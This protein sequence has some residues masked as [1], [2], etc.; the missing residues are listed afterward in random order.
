MNRKALLPIAISLGVFTV[1]FAVVALFL[2]NASQNTVSNAPSSQTSV[3][4][5]AELP[6]LE[7][8]DTPLAT[9]RQVIGGDLRVSGN[10]SIIDGLTSSSLQLTPL[11]SQTTLQAGQLYTSNDNNL[12]YYNGQTSAN[13][14]G[15]LSAAQVDIAQLQADTAQL[16]TQP[17][18]V[19][20]LQG[21]SGNVVL[22]G[23]SGITISGT[24][25]SNSGVLTVQGRA[26]NV[27]FVGANGISV[28]GTTITNTGVTSL[29]GES[30]ALAVGNGLSVSGG[31]LVNT[32]ITQ[33][34]SNSADLIVSNTGGG[35]YTISYAGSG[36]G[37]TV[38]LAPLVAQED[39]SD[40]ASI[41]FNKTGAGNLIQL[42]TGT[43]ASNKFVVDQT[44]TI[45]NGSINFSQVTGVPSLVN[46]IAGLTGTI[47]LGA[48]LSVSAG[49]L[50]A[51]TS[52]NNLVGTA[53]QINV[54]GSG[55]L[56]LS[57]PQNIA[58][59]SS[60]TFAGLTLTNALSIANGGTGAVTP[61]GA[62]TN[63]GAAA[64]GANSDITSLSGLTTALSVAQ[65]GTGTT[66]LTQNGVL[67]GN[68]TSAVTALTSSAPNQCLVSS[69]LGELSFS[70]C[71][72]AGGVTSLNSKTGAVTIAGLDPTSIDS[73]GASIII[74]DA[75]ASVK[76]LASFN[77]TNFAVLNG[78]VNTVQDI[79]IGAA[80][81]FAGLTLTSA[82]SVANGGTGR[83]SFATNGV[84]LGQGTG[85]LT[86][87]STTTAGLCLVSGTGG[88]LSFS[89]C[90]GATGV[91]SLNGLTGGLTLGV[92]TASSLSQVGSTITI[93][94]AS[95]VIKGLAAFNE[96]NLT[97]TNGVVNT[98]QDINTGATPTFA[99]LTLTSAL[100]VASGGT[101][102][103]T[104]SANSLLIGNG[105]NALSTLSTTVAGQCLA[106]GVGGVL[107][108][109]TCPGAEVVNTLNG[110]SGAVSVTAV[111]P[112]S[113]DTASGV[114]TI[115]DASYTTK[116]LASFN[117]SNFS[118]LDGAVN[119]VQ[120]IGTTASPTF[121]GLSLTTALGVANGGTGA[122]NFAANGVLVGQGASAVTTVG[123]SA[124]GQ[125]LIS[126][127]GGYLSFAT[128]P[129]STGVVSV[130][131][132]VGALTVR[133]VSA[134]SVLSSGTTVTIQDASDTVKG[135]ASF[136]TTNFTV[137]NGAVNTVQDI[138]IDA[139]PTFAGLSLSSPLAVSSGGTGR[140]S[141]TLNGVV[142]GNGASGLLT[143]AATDANQC[144]VSAGDGSLSFVTC[145]G[146][147]G[148]NSLNSLTGAITLNAADPNS[149]SSSGTTITLRDATNVRKG[150]AS[151]DAANFTVASGAVNTVQ[152]IG[153]GATPTFASINLTAPL[154]V[155]NGG[156]GATTAVG[157]R[158]NLGAA[159]S[160]VNTDITSLGSVTD[161]ASSAD[162]TISAT[163]GTVSLQGAAMVLAR[164]NGVNSTQLVFADPSAD[165]IYTLQTAAAGTYDVC[166]TAGNCVGVGGGVTTEGGTVGRLSR[167]V[168]GSA[169]GDSI[170][171]DNGSTVSIAGALSVNTITPT[172]AAV[173]GAVTQSLTLQGS[174]TAI[175]ATDDATTNTLTFATPSGANK[176]ITIPNAS[177]TIAIS[178]TG[179]LVLDS[180]GNLTCPTCLTSGGGGGGATG[181]STVNGITGDITIT[182]SD[183]N[184][185]TTAGT[186]ITI[187][188]ATATRKGIASFNNANLVVTNGNVNTIQD[189][190]TTA[191]P[192]FAGL[193]LTSPLAV[194][195]GGTGRANLPQGLLLGNGTD[196]VEI[197]APTGAS[198]CLASNEEGDLVFVTCPGT[199]VVNFLN[200][201]NG[202]ITIDTVSASS[203]SVGSNSILIQDATAAI[204]GLASFESDNL[205]VTNG[206]VNTIQDISTAAAP[207][208]NGLTLSTALGVAS[209]GTGAST[210]GAARVNLGAAARGANSDITSLSGLTTA[211]SVSQGGTGQTSLAANRVL[212]GNGTS[213]V[214][215]TNAAGNGLCLVGNS[216]G[217]PSFQMCPG[218]DGVSSLN[219]LQGEVTIDT[220]GATS[221]LVSGNNIRIQDATSS[222]KGLAS[223]DGSNLVVT[224]GA[225]TTAQN[226]TASATPTFAGLNLTAAL[227]VASGGTG[228]TSFTT[229]GILVGQGAGA[230]TTVATTTAG[231]CLVSGTGGSLSFATCPGS[232][233]VSSVNSLTGDVTID[234]VTASSLQVTGNTIRIQD[235][236]S[237]TKGLA[238]FNTDS[239][240]VTNGAV[241]TVQS[242]NTSATPT[243]A[244]LTLTTPLGVAS[245]G[246]GR[247][248]LPANALVIGNGTGAVTSLGTS[249]SGKC[250]VSGVGGVLSFVDCPG[251]D[252][253]NSI[254]GVTGAVSL[255]AVDPAS[256]DTTGSTITIRDA[257]Y[258]TKGLA[259]FNGGNFIVTNG[260]VN[261]IQNISLTATPTFAGLNL[262]TALGVGS[263]GTGSTNFA[264]NSLLVGQGASAVTTV[265]TSTAGQCLVSGT[266]G[267]LSFAACP[268]ANGV[269]SFNSLAGAITL[270]TV[271]A[272]SLLTSGNTITIADASDTIKGLAAFNEDNLTVT[273]GLVNTIQDISTASAPTFAG[274]TLTNALS[275]ANGGTGQ[276][277][278][279]ANRVL[280]GNGS[281][282][283][284]VTNAAAAGQ[285][286]IGNGVGAPSFQACPVGG[287]ISSGTSQTAG[288]VAMF[289]TTTNQ[290]TDSLLSQAGGVVTVDGQL[291]ATSLAGNGSA[292]TGL[293]A[294]N[295]SS[296]TLANARLSSSVTLQG[297]TFNGDSQLVK[298]D[299][300]GAALADGLCLMSTA[301]GT[302]TAFQACPG[303]GG[304]EGAS[305]SLSNLSNVA[306][307]DVLL[308]GAS[309]TID[310]GSSSLLFHDLYLGGDISAAGAINGLSLTSTSLQSAGALTISSGGTNQTLTLAGS[311]T[312]G[313]TINGGTGA[314]TL[315]G[316]SCSAAAN[317]GKL[318]TNGAGAITCADDIGGVTVVGTINAQTASANGASISGNTIYLQTA[319]AS[320]PGLVSTGTQ[321]FG[322]NK[323]FNGQVT[324][325]SGTTLQ[326]TLDVSGQS[327]FTG[328]VRIGTSG[329]GVLYTDG[330]GA[331]QK[332]STSGV[333]VG[334]CLGYTGTNTLGF[335]SCGGSG[336]TPFVQGGNAFNATA[337]LGTTDN[338]GVNIVQNGANRIS[339]PNDG[340]I[341]LTPYTNKFVFINT[342]ASDSEADLIV[343]GRIKS[344]TGFRSGNAN[345]V[346]ISQCGGYI[347]NAVVSGGIITNGNCST[348]GSAG[349]AIVQ[350]GNAFNQ[351]LTMGTT[352]N[353]GINLVKQG[354]VMMAI[355][356]D[357]NIDFNPSA[358]KWVR[359]GTSNTD[360]EAQ[361]IV[362]G[363]VKSLT[364]FRVGNSNGITLTCSNGNQTLG[365]PR[366]EGGIITQASC[367]TN[368]SDLAENYAST[369]NLA[370]AEIVMAAGTAPTAVT[371]ATAA[372]REK[373]MGVVSTE[374]AQTLGTEQVPEG[375]PI[376]LTGRVPVKVNGEGGAIAI[377]DKITISSVAGVGKKATNAGMIV[378]TAVETF[379]GVGQGS[380]EVFVNLMYW[381]P[382]TSNFLQAQSAEFATV[383]VTSGLTVTGA[384]TFNSAIV[385]NGHIVTGGGA[386]NYTVG[387]AAG[388]GATIAVEG[389]D[390]AGTIT[391]TTGSGVTAGSLADLV[392]S[393]QYGKSPR[394]IIS[395]Q[396]DASVSARVYPGAKSLSGFSLS[397][398][399]T[400]APNTTYTFDYFIVE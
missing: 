294:T 48:G 396:D 222:I 276:T 78:S 41:A 332:V 242:I 150:L 178:A 132:L 239:L 119:T 319:S 352:D 315:A 111:D 152:D 211:L 131:G 156:T 369:D 284:A 166:T 164:D 268:G 72:G 286:L 325:A 330:G 306:I 162:L 301:S 113:I 379:N 333:T 213:G 225:V 122:T 345:G 199:S 341:I 96:E 289:D 390:T 75:S 108:F 191:T 377:G 251:T 196:P 346:N 57:L 129:G 149:I 250:L 258:T 98:I 24:T 117:G 373:L 170:I 193:T 263:G 287:N 61:G 20:T 123:A 212:L 25:I 259:S 172:A 179:P 42:S 33:I 155:N 273:N 180:N 302:G 252:V 104:I 187:N 357:G 337:V 30:G 246:T 298:L 327:T 181:V 209:G 364:G 167:F 80:P 359:I 39:S 86:S 358:N 262:S 297:N 35:V 114:I 189:I 171:T 85:A 67:I 83:T 304:S 163:S 238:S 204:K 336:G 102:L 267:V 3:S 365:A 399:Q 305:T 397:T 50:V 37:G 372:G 46:S 148:V 160:G 47:G 154:N 6:E 107:S 317:G 323:T 126:G 136:N 64:S 49:Q 363:R 234:T 299:S 8:D 103:S 244:G 334:Y 232:G 188:D 62:R 261:T 320:A 165:V 253:V 210:A 274:L 87:V 353:F 392:F 197:L 112:T 348:G 311:G 285:C 321:S 91:T 120:N 360:G 18:A 208:F 4:T 10:V 7:V 74:R 279:A 374:P 380:I 316:F 371:R 295:I 9:G 256:I 174:T 282:G 52:V 335:Q 100:D 23:T 200:G 291:T 11:S 66:S 12:Y 240:T 230:L 264:A 26:G 351:T 110:Q 266:G 60:P 368:N 217:A 271:T 281:S 366:I 236:T 14:S 312:G 378:G 58:T 28:S 223:F 142:V 347:Q 1:I 139:T 138:T 370:P 69:A 349:Q 367:S 310:I 293:N 387:A 106:S 393:H 328:T 82:L 224:N 329:M 31:T 145:P 216:S 159:A 116:G 13:I 140:S 93:N 2:W 241:S 63:L 248:S 384:A 76:G 283:I 324:V 219:S 194:S 186:T 84:L 388:A 22:T 255:T 201:I 231:Q 168:S 158:A 182:A 32:G 192:T 205:T 326:S 249:L 40:N 190:S 376:A 143:V 55:T 228:R 125:C 27:Q 229:N 34:I 115:K 88:S 394:V 322:G 398:A 290:I 314:I 45:I 19:V 206:H 356:Q 44:G 101:G 278:L 247:S 38:A 391:V 68:G 227:G 153:T 237:S 15:G 235:A 300:G 134:A 303:S 243:F 395:G 269:T 340:N 135:L 71:P 105:T 169:I 207:T 318:T 130:N 215:V 381:S 157:A 385:V 175:T 362:N 288:V 185:I 151:F 195:S 343:N 220:V 309:N 51:T 313:V 280:L 245:G 21:Q 184:T 296:G 36:A 97:V 29:G 202:T 265:G 17:E 308:P 59:T 144:L 275:V 383:N 128:C 375:Y 354:S 161:L 270:T 99:G 307:N 400:L 70:S 386:P 73:T 339:M 260:D 218:S 233:G 350:G 118:V 109:V 92:V 65:G 331:V 137:T 176:T 198:E 133:G 89:T 382:V 43:S 56:T 214:A 90:P 257:S 361:L 53:N 147:T 226:I 344:L 95:E 389:N 254:N 124:E 221:L 121:E 94:D 292:I 77:G 127:S 203:L 146:A 355:S 277:S 183:A 272:S 177:G 141:F 81:T 173:I 342:T 79:N 54:T 5:V 16:L 338:H